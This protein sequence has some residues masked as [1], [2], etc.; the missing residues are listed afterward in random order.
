[1]CERKWEVFLKLEMEFKS[2]SD[3]GKRGRS[4]YI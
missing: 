3:F 1:M 2:C 4:K